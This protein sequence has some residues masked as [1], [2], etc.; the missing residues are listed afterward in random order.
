M[1]NVWIGLVIG[2]LTGAV[3][4]AVANA[5]RGA[6]RRVQEA[7]FGTRAHDAATKLASSVAE[8]PVGEMGKQ[9]GHLV[10]DTARRA[11]KFAEEHVPVGGNRR[12]N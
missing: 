6:E 1:K 2:A 5:V 4:G 10:A 12:A 11:E 7:D 8:S 9:A 3:V